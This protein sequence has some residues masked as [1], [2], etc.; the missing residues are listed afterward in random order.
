VDV[1]TEVVDAAGDGRLQ[2][3]TVRNRSTGTTRDLKAAALFVM[4]GAVPH[5]EWLDPDIARDPAGYLLTGEQ[6]AGL[7][8]WPLERAPLFLE[9]CVP[10]VFAVGDV[11]H[12]ATRRV[13]PSVGAGAIAVQLVHQYLSEAGVAQ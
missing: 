11:R 8:Q 6:V 3:L 9:T 5:T 1:S 7:A 2:S 4:I 12:G 13:A 10:G